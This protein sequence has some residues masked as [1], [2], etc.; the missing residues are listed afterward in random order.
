MTQTKFWVPI[1]HTATSKILLETPR[2]K[3]GLLIGLIS[4]HNRLGRHMAKLDSRSPFCRLCNAGQED[5]QHL[6]F[7]CKHLE[8]LVLE[9]L[10]IFTTGG[11]HWTVEGLRQF[12][13]AGMVR[14]LL[15]S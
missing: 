5:T 8:Q 7:N 9:C 3:L 6:V 13:N 4:G 11:G 1:P 15:T 14:W 12:A 10:G 2:F